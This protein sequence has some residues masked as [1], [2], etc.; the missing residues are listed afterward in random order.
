[1]IAVSI[2]GYIRQIV[3]AFNAG[4]HSEAIRISRTALVANHLDP[5]LNH[6]LA[7]ACF[8]IQDNVGA[9][10]AGE[11]SLSVRP[12]D[13]KVLLIC[14]RAARALNRLDLAEMHFRR[15]PE[16]F[17]EG[18]IEL[19]RTLEMLGKRPHAQKIWAQVRKAQPS[20]REAAARLGRLQWEDGHFENARALLE[21]AV[22]DNAPASAWFDLGLARQDCGDIAGAAEAFENAF[23]RSPHDADAAFNLG[24]ALQLLGNIQ[25]AVEA[26]RAAYR[27]SPS[28][29]GM[30]ANA[31]TSGSTGRMFIDVAAL[32]AFIGDRIDA[33]VA[34][35]F[36]VDS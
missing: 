36:P 22:E 20:S 7:A 34:K 31:L 25:G 28:Q 32:K 18:R 15:L 33:P 13:P 35:L 6:L 2:E 23:L 24:S 8:A 4:E 21:L 16:N 10:A 14:G 17:L 1:M 5:V 11:Q 30:I 9:L 26:Y 12:D 27:I 19:A 3:A 29:L